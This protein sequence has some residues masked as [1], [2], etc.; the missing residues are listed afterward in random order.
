MSDGAAALET[1][2]SKRAKE[3]DR[4][5][6][7]EEALLAGGFARYALRRLAAFGVA[8][9]LATIVHVIE[10]TFLFEM[11]R[12]KP[13][14]ASLALQNVTLVVDAFFW[15]ALEAYR[16]KARELGPSSEA[17][18]LAGRWMSLALRIG[19]LVFIA[20]VA[21][22]GWTVSHQPSTAPML[23][24][25]ACICGVRLAL[26]LV[27]RSYYSGVFAYR[28]VHRPIWSTLVAPACLL[29][30][31][32]LLWNTIGAWS[33]V[34]ALGL[35]VFVTRG[36]LLVF[37]RRAYRRHH[38]PA[39]R[40]TWIWRNRR[41]HLS[42]FAGAGSAGAANLTSRVGSVVLLAAVIPS[43][44]TDVDFGGGIE[45]LAFAL[46]LASPL[47]LM[48]SQWTFVF[49]HDEKRLEDEGSEALGHRFQRR[50]V[51]LG[52]LVG[53]L[54]WGGVVLI[55]LRFLTW[56]ETASTLQP[57]MPATIGLAL[58]SVAQLRTF[59]RGEFATQAAAAF[60]MLVVASL[61]VLL[62]LSQSAWSN[63]SLAD[64]DEP[65]S[66]VGLAIAPWAGILVHVLVAHTV[67]R[68]A[69]LGAVLSL[70][71]WTRALRTVKGPVVVWNGAVERRPAVVAERIAA[72]LGS[73]GAV[74]VGRLRV[75][76]FERVGGSPA[77]H[78][79]NRKVWLAVCGGLLRTL[80]AYR[81][82]TGAMAAGHLEGRRVLVGPE[83]GDNDLERLVRRHEE[84]F[85]EG[86][87][88]TLG[89]PPP[90]RFLELP[91]A[92]RQAIWRDGCSERSRRG[93]ARPTSGWRVVAFAPQGPV[94]ALFVRPRGADPAKAAAWRSAVSAH[95]W[96]IDTV[97]RLSDGPRKR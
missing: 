88:L 44:V 72:S 6:A 12:A 2:L 58:L 47:L 23:A 91:P 97:P 3:A 86:F 31:V 83:T 66:L 42:D 49:Y 16:R 9:G 96:R 11:F 15:G 37:S 30:G 82:E 87:V 18:A 19:V 46:H 48:A 17:A 81:E 24:A 1:W 43:L 79:P 8:R 94:T 59:A 4:I 92:I 95:H 93:R 74:H 29:G 70:P 20:T 33:F 54:A 80:E 26:D 50:L 45:P 53:L 13:F 36:L 60:A 38:I 10:L 25:Y 64:R 22:A 51:A 84:L 69:R 71:A 52:V 41:F 76:W 68:R 7:L 75:L 65:P 63:L 56:Q 34:I 21:F 5:I 14:M 28:R 61:V 32:F 27:L 40:L 62:G 73:R 90:P 77:P 55:V 39:P 78:R 85:P 57:L 89:A 67:A 35:S